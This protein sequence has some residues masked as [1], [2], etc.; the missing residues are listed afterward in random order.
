[1]LRRT[2]ALL[3]FFQK[4]YSQCSAKHVTGDA[5]QTGDLSAGKVLSRSA[6]AQLFSVST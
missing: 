3:L 4:V 6:M 1:M 2:E 5:R